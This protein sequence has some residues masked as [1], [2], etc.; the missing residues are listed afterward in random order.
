M[1][2]GNFHSTVIDYDKWFSDTEPVKVIVEKN[3]NKNKRKIIYPA[4]S[5]C[6]NL[7]N[8]IFWKKK[9]NIWASGKLPNFFTMQDNTIV[10]KKKLELF[11]CELGNDVNENLNNAMNFF[12]IHGNIFSTLEND[13]QT[14]YKENIKK[15]NEALKWRGLSKKKQEYLIRLYVDNQSLALGLD[16]DISNRLMQTIRLAFSDKQYNKNN[17]VLVNGKISEING[18]LW[19]KNTGHFKSDFVKKKIIKGKVEE[20]EA[21]PKDMIPQFHVKMIKYIEEYD[22]IFKKYNNL[23]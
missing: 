12:R 2:V 1:Q 7:T 13:E 6:A 21:Y 11:T 23:I 8:D 9:F 20:T 14:E 19:D 16:N 15:T 18:L 3:K 10:F 4:F 5:A 22:K 17:I